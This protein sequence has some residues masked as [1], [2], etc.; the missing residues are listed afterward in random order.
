MQDLTGVLKDTLT[1][2]SIALPMIL[3]LLAGFLTSLSPC[4][5]PLIPITLSIIGARRYNGRLQGF[6]MS[7]AY[8]LGMCLVYA[9]LGAS[10]AYAGWLAGSVM[11]SPV[12]LSLIALI[13]FIFALSMFDVFQLFIPDFWLNRLSRVGGIGYRGAFLMGMVAGLIAA[14]CTGPVLGFILTLIASDQNIGSGMV[15]MASFSLGMGLP[16]LALGT[17]S[18][19]IA[20]LPKS[21]PWMKSIKSLLGTIMIGVSLYY[22]A[23]AYDGLS[24][25]LLILASAGLLLVSAQIVIGALLVLAPAKMLSDRYLLIARRGLGSVMLALGLASLL[26]AQGLNLNPSSSNIKTNWH[27]IDASSSGT[28]AFEALLMQARAENKK[29]LIDFYADWCVACR[30]LSTTTFSDNRVLSALELYFLIKVDSSTN[31]AWLSDLQNR[32]MVTGL[33]T[34]IFLDQSSRMLKQS[35]ILGYLSPTQFL[36]RLDL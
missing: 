6:F 32:F 15:L 2:G 20:H 3:A 27:V 5:Y 30:K 29:V 7:G 10:F 22:L 19:A 33:P 4:V 9:I 31:I 35:T 26:N 36:E 28:D 11:S 18:S 16:F 12:V 23:L 25:A 13:F 21:G 24:R 34:I 14:P 8:V 17:F 1:S